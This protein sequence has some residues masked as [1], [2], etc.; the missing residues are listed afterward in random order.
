MRDGTVVMLRYYDAQII[1][2]KPLAAAASSSS[3]LTPGAVVRI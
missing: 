3:S 2:Y 1:P